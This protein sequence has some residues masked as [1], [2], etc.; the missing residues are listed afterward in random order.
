MTEV[1]EWHYEVEPANGRYRAR[2]FLNGQ[3]LKCS[4]F[5]TEEHAQQACKDWAAAQ[6]HR[7]QEKEK[8]PRHQ[9]KY[10]GRHR[11]KGRK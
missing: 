10:D 4:W 2:Q 9:M 5:D 3:L 8:G 11:A 6:G 1:Q 7:P